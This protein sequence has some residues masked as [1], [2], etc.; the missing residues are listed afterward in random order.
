[1]QNGARL[2]VD[3]MNEKGDIIPGFVLSLYQIDDQHNPAQAVSVAKK[4]VSD[5]DVVGVVG[6]FNS[7]CSKPAS[8]VYHEA[9]L[10]QVTPGSTNPEISKQ[11]FDTFFRVCASDDIQGP[12]GASFAYNRLGARRIFLIDD[13]T[14]Y[15]K[16]LADEFEKQA[17]ALGMKIHGHEGI[18]Q[19]DKDFTP[20][21]TRIKA[22]F[23]DLIFFGG[24]YP[25]GALLVRQAKSLG[26][27]ATFMG[28]DGISDRTFIKLATP[29]LAEGTYFTMVGADITRVPSAKDFVSAFQAKYGEPGAFSAYG[30]DAAGVIIDAI[31]RAGKKDRTA[32]LSEVRNTKDYRGATGTINF[33]RYGDTT[34]KF[35]GVFNVEAGKFNYVG[36]AE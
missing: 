6:H 1:M 30:Y 16:G 7:S 4:F 8:S 36:K 5:R 29:E 3:Q 11:G 13:K 17:K 14:T 21:L 23:V 15:G 22:L 24:I 31:K 32:V 28:G 12:A 25:E 33:D 18:T 9:R 10:V 20:L 26:I 2:A 35:I 19:G 27:T 34:N